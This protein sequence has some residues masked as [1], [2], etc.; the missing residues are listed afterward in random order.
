MWNG[1]RSPGSAGARARET[2]THSG[3]LCPLPS[4]LS[5]SSPVSPALTGPT[6][7]GLGWCWALACWL[8]PLCPQHCPPGSLWAA[9]AVSSARVAVGGSIAA[10]VSASLCA[11]LRFF[12]GSRNGNCL[13]RRPG[14]GQVQPLPLPMRGPLTLF[15]ASAEAV[16]SN[17]PPKTGKTGGTLQCSAEHGPIRRR[18]PRQPWNSPRGTGHPPKIEGN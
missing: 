8:Q 5:P 6:L 14:L 3:T 17:R 2:R 15:C 1:K 4:A 7:S 12:G 16:K 10:G 18:S 9:L 11:H 13:G